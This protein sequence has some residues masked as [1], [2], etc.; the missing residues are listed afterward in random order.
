MIRRDNDMD[1]YIRDSRAQFEEML[2]EM[3]QIPSISMD[4]H[5]AEDMSR[6]ASLA[7]QFLRGMGADAQIVRTDGYPVVSGGWMT[8]KQYPIV[9]RVRDVAVAMALVLHGEEPIDYAYEFLVLYK[10]RG[11][12]MR[13][14]TP[15]Y[16]FRTEDA[17]KVAHE[18]AHAFFA[19]VAKGK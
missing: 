13:K 11:P 16:G 12:E 6:M 19:K 3:I 14:K 2:A 17:R 1:P 4:P 10:A 8:N 9:T 7:V 18:K 15:F 5:H